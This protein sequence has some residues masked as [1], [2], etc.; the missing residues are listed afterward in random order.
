V[1]C[2]GE[3]RAHQRV[4]RRRQ[5]SLLAFYERLDFA[6]EDVSLSRAIPADL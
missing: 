3:L 4:D 2:C 1:G 5:R 6:R